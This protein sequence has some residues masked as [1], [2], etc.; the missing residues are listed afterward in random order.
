M[1]YT[2]AKCLKSTCDVTLYCLHQLMM[3]F[4][5]H[6]DNFYG[7]IGQVKVAVRKDCSSIES[8]RLQQ[9][10][11]QVASL[12]FAMALQSH[13]PFICRFSFW[14]VREEQAPSLI[15][16]LRESART[17]SSFIPREEL[18]SKFPSHRS[19][20]KPAG[21]F[22]LFV[23]E[24]SMLFAGCRSDRWLWVCFRISYSC[25]P[26]AV[27]FCRIHKSASRLRIL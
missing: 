20:G 12:R 19:Q 16:R 14:R 10:A 11:Q 3:P 22:C 18:S 8:A 4:H 26:L 1:W 21:L 24:A 9:L 25:R 5:A 17:F 6:S 7:D 15:T 13:P 23:V 2:A 27:C